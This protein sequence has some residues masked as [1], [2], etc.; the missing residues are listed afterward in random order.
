MRLFISEIFEKISGMTDDALKIKILKENEC[1]PIKQILFAGFSPDVKFLLPEGPTPYKP[2][3]VPIGLA[4]TNL[5]R[6]AR[7]LYL[8]VSV[9]GSVG[10]SRLPQVK[11]EALWV[12]LLEQVQKDE[13]LVL[14]AVKNRQL[15]S[16]YR[17][18]KSIVDAVFPG[19]LPEATV[20]K[21]ATV[22]VTET[23]VVSSKKKRG[24]KKVKAEVPEL[25][26]PDEVP[27]N[28]SKI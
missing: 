7:K 1:I 2:K 22:Q 15:E 5:Y 26:I 17:I 20:A 14:D 25:I 19:M 21:A 16:K 3:D 6:E 8:F 28:E 13:A 24:P 10:N 27:N 4:D 9:S 18:T 11:R 23:E 12:N